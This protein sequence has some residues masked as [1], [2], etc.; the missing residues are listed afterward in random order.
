MKATDS[1][2]LAYYDLKVCRSLPQDNKL[3]CSYLKNWNP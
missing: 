1:D 3:E 2:I